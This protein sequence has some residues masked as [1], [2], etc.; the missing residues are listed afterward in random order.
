MLFLIVPLDTVAHAT[1]FEV[2]EMADAS[3]ANLGDNICDR[4]LIAPGHQC[5]L[6]AA[7]EQ[8]NALAGSDNL[9][10]SV[11]GLYPLTIGQL[12]VTS[13]ITLNGN[14]SIFR[15]T[16][17][18]KFRIFYVT[19][20]GDLTLN[21]VTIRDGDIAAAGGGI[22]IESGGIVNIHNSTI[23][24]NTAIGPGGGIFNEG[25]LNIHNSAILTNTTTNWGGGIT[26]SG[27][28]LNI[29]NSTISGNIANHDGGGIDNTGAGSGGTAHLTNVT[30]TNNIANNDR[31]LPGTGGGIF[32]FSGTV[33]LKNSLITGNID[34]PANPTSGLN[35]PDVG[36]T[37]IS[38]GFNL[39]GNIGTTSFNSQPGDQ[40]GTSGSPI[41][42][43]LGSL[44]SN[45]AYHPLL[46]GSPAIDQIPVATN[47]IFI[48]S[49]TNPLFSDGATINADQRGVVR[50]L[51]G[52]NNGT[53]TCDIGAY[54][55]I[56]PIYLPIILKN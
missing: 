20:T 38:H 28:T 32:R 54:E 22:R 17:V 15:R 33:N 55:F 56:A 12:L 21:D 30:I 16:G 43:R 13:H 19:G 5:T 47:C 27:G 24:N 34:T 23:S 53:F 37:I 3:D 49:G 41:N 7:I 52:D 35:K 39:I 31:I 8:A 9:T 44:T 11:P 51:D 29:A 25:R 18:G 42:P 46:I 6:R 40:V 45:P 2:N 1:N 14:G 26:N 4:D 36:G 50:P 48:S 10:L